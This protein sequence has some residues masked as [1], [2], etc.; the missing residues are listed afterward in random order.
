M[1]L[2]E[3]IKSG[4]PFRRHPDMSWI[5]VKGGVLYYNRA[6]DGAICEQ[7]LTVDSLLAD[8]WEIQEPTVTITRTQLQDAYNDARNRVGDCSN[9]GAS[10]FI[11][12]AKKL[13]LGL[14]DK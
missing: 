8:D 4:R 5:Y 7:S 6:S 9:F 13:G 14:G 1:N 12:M 3:A 10:T 11:V 2:I